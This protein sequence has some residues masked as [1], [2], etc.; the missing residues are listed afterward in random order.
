MRHAVPLYLAA[1]LEPGHGFQRLKRNGAIAVGADG[2]HRCIAEA[3]VV[4][5]DT[6]LATD[7]V[8]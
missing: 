5:Y 1:V 8:D 4:G 7:C 6:G 3:L 2:Q